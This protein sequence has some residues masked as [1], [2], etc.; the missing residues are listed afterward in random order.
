MATFVRD[1]LEN[2]TNMDIEFIDEPDEEVGERAEILDKL[3][4]ATIR[5]EFP[6]SYQKPSIGIRKGWQAV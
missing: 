5:Q 3:L 2:F 6:E 1:L 4:W